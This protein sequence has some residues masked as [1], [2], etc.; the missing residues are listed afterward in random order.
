MENRTTATVTNVVLLKKRDGV[1]NL[2]VDL[3]LDDP[4]ETSRAWYDLP[5]DPHALSFKKGD[6][7]D[8]E[9]STRES[10]GKTYYNSTILTA[11]GS[12]DPETH[13]KELQEKFEVKE[14]NK[15]S[16]GGSALDD[17]MEN[18]HLC[19]Q[20]VLD[21]VDFMD[22]LNNSETDEAV[23]QATASLFIEG[24]RKNLF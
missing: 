15:V 7:V 21:H 20:A 13:L 14:N 2:V 24:N 19:R 18:F 6:R 17:L 10:R 5:D 1:L 12:A 11:S 9:W 4:S 23:R 3:Q 8:V 16:N 22:S